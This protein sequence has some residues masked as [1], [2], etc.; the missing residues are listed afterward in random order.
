MPRIVLAT[1]GSLGDLHPYIAIA[2]GLKARGHQAVIATSGTYRQKVEELG[3]GFHAVRPDIPDEN[4]KTELVRRIMDARTGPETVV[5]EIVM[6]MLRE[7]YADTQAVAEGADLL[8]GHPLT[9]TTRLVAEK[10]GVPWVSSVLAPLS[11]FSAYDPPVILPLPLLWRLRFLGPWLFGPLFRL[12]RLKVRRWCEPVHRLRAELGL[13]PAG[14]PLFEGAHSPRLVLAPFS[15]LLGA[16]ARDWPAQTAVTG[17][18][19]YDRDGAGG[20]SEEL[21]RFLDAGDAPLVFTL[22]SS[23]VMDA[24][25][26]YHHSAEAARQLGRR[27][28]LLVGKDAR[29]RPAKL[30]DGVVAFDYA[31]YSELL[32]RAAAVVHQGGVGT[33]GQAMRAG[34]PMLVMPYAHDQFDNAARVTRLGIARTVRRHQYDAGRAV[35]ELRPLLADARYAE[36]ARFV[37]EQVQAEDGVGKACD[38]LERVL[39]HDRATVGS[40]SRAS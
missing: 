32:P 29:N 2:L 14:D 36:K 5:R 4:T 21:A 23:A 17:F 27:A 33:T 35:R 9:F 28:V 6:P 30:P 12:G 18:A 8:V 25:Q 19:F 24:G 15:R 31:P 13:P 1:F 3:L 22:G 37:G 26:F 38:E 16:P 10:R 40:A 20:M 7:S 39:A 11:F 34:R